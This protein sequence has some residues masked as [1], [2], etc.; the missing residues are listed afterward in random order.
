MD[1]ERYLGHA[2][3][4]E[5]T[6]EPGPL[7]A[8]FGFAPGEDD[9]GGIELPAFELAEGVTLR[10][11]IDRIDLGEGGEAVVYDYKNRDAP[12]PAKWIPEGKLQVALYMCAAE[13]L[14]GVRAVGGFYQ[15]LSGEDL[16]PRGL[17]DSDSGAELACVRGDAREHSEVRELLGEALELA[18]S[19]AAEAGAGE[20]ESRPSSCGWN[21]SGC[22]YP[23]ICRCER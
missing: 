13:A 9:G 17:L 5:S 21:G 11:R 18:R 1:L 8:G 6:L 7:E 19:A 15:P 16:R 23:A 3:S 12:A 14:L 10:G 2:A 20:F 4:V 22:V